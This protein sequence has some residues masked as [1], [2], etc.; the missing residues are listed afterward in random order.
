MKDSGCYS[1]E[2]EKIIVCTSKRYELLKRLFDISISFLG[3][4]VFF[5]L[6]LIIMVYMSYKLYGPVFTYREVLGYRGRSFKI[7]RFYN[8]K[9]NGERIIGYIESSLNQGL[10][11]KMPDEELK[12]TVLDNLACSKFITTLLQLVNVLKGDMSIVG[13]KPKD[14]CRM[15]SGNKWYCVRLSAKPGIIGLWDAYKRYD[16]GFDEMVWF[17][18][19]YLKE[20]RLMY[21]MK[22]IA[23]VLI[24]RITHNK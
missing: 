10:G 8:R 4:L 9:E 5:P 13:P 17:D 18:L 12:I 16:D 15:E 19:K 7:Y 2:R 21:D 1:V 11:E 14:G 23:R 6:L 22:I 3:L 24:S 20:R